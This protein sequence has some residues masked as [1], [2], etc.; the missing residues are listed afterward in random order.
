M[1]PE[2]KEKDTYKMH[3]GGITRDLNMDN[4]VDDIIEWMFIFLSGLMTIC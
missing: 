1:N 2:S 3:F 4:R